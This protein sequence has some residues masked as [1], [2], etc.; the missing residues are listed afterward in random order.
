MDP[1]YI[2]AIA[3]LLGSVVGALSTGIASWFTQRAQEQAKAR[4]HEVSRREDLYREFIVAA[5]KTYAE[6]IVT[7]EPQL[8][9]LI[10]LYG[11]VS[12]MRVVCAPRTVACAEKVMITTIET[13]FKPNKTI[14]EVHDM[15]ISGKGIDPLQEFSAAAR[16]ELRPWEGRATKHA[17]LESARREHLATSGSSPRSDA[18]RQALAH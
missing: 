6:A 15:M 12:Q 9:E 10:A 14:L 13:F 7:S 4:A 2:S 1:A 3:A 8:P 11:M 17:S 5:S 18:A 16:D